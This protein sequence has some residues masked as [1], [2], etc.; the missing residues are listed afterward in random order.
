MM[1]SYIDVIQREVKPLVSSGDKIFADLPGPQ[2]FLFSPHITHTDLRPNIVI[3]N[4]EPCT[5]CLVEL[6]ICFDTRFHEAHSLKQAKYAHLVLSIQQASGYIPELITLE[7]G[8]RGPLNPKG[9]D[10]LK[11]YVMAPTKQWTA[12]LT[13]IMRTVLMES[14]K[15]WT[16]RNWKDPEH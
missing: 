7:V 10:K 9:F 16:M 14:H 3:W 15:I 6:T 4:D 5:V 11:A 8:S 13:A 2:P 1:L 12:M